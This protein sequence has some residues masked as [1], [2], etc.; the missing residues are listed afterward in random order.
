MEDLRE[1]LFQIQMNRLKRLDWNKKFGLY[2]MGLGLFVHYI[3]ALVIYLWP[4]WVLVK[5]EVGYR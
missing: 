1:E 2:W 3:V 4:E 5:E